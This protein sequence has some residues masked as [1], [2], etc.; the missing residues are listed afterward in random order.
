MTLRNLVLAPTLL[1]LCL[2]VIAQRSRGQSESG[3]NP[4][5][6]AG[7]NKPAEPMKLPP[8]PADK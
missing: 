6:A 4:P 8:M 7:A 2:P 5:A 1:V 3:D